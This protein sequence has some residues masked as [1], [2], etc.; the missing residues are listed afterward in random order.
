MDRFSRLTVEDLE[1]KTNVSNQ[2]ELE[3]VA[4]VISQLSSISKKA[5]PLPLYEQ[6]TFSQFTKRDHQHSSLLHELDGSPRYSSRSNRVSSYLIEHPEK[7]NFER[8]ISVESLRTIDGF[9][10]GAADFSSLS[11]KKRSVVSWLDHSKNAYRDNRTISGDIGRMNFSGNLG[12]FFDEPSQKLVAV[13]DSDGSSGIM[14][15]FLSAPKKVWAFIKK[16]LFKIG[17][18]IEV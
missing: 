1:I 15:Y 13:F 14:H 6:Q 7:H 3:G 17:A 11:I 5:V 4:Y 16:V 18:S 9:S 12:L 10:L 2:K 8:K